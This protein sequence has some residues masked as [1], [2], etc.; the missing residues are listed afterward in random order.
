MIND[1]IAEIAAARAAA[2]RE[3]QKQQKQRTK[4]PVTAFHAIVFGIT[5]LILLVAL[6]LGNGYA[7]GELIDA[8]SISSSSSHEQHEAAVEA[9]GSSKAILCFEGD[10]ECAANALKKAELPKGANAEGKPLDVS[11]NNCNDRH[12]QCAGFKRND[13]CNKNPGWMI[14]NCPKSCNACH[15]L[16]PKVRCNRANLNIS[17]L[18]AYQPG[19]MSAMFSSIEERFQDRYGVNVL[20]TDPYV[21][22]FDNFMTDREVAALIKAVEG[23]WERSTDTGQSNEFG[24]TGRV[25]SQ[26]RTS[27]NSWCRRECENNPDVKRIMQKIEEVTRVPIDN[28][29][30][31]QV[32]RYELG[33]K[34]NAHHDASE[35][36]VRLSCGPRILTFFLY[37]SDV[38]EGGETGFPQLGINVKPKKGS[39]LLWPSTLD[40]NPEQIDHRTLHEVSGKS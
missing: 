12:E 11:L 28:Y 31:F 21:V 27:S 18:P 34:Y 20:S 10:E 36:Q 23:G 37:L 9:D 35:S 16:D 8:S 38:E 40:S 32:L 4:A 5:A 7:F 26:G 39:A 14:V 6:F 2:Q 1:K 3:R 29:E 22:T 25:L 15:L 30:S 17:T 33:Q 19:E 13:E 24:E